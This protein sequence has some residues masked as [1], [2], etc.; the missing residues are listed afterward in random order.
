LNVLAFDAGD[1]GTGGSASRIGK[2]FQ[3]GA[4]MLSRISKH[5]SC[6]RIASA[7]AA[8]PGRLSARRND[9]NVRPQIRSQ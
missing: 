8:S 9:S 3:L 6:D 7:Y 1:S 2:L 5:S 4:T